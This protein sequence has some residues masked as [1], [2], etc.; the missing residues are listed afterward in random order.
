[1]SCDT[2]TQLASL[3]APEGVAFE[4][5]SYISDIES[6]FGS[7]L[8]WRSGSRNGGK[9]VEELR[10]ELQRTRNRLQESLIHSGLWDLEDARDV[11]GCT[12]NQA[13]DDAYEAASLNM[14][15]LKPDFEQRICLDSLSMLLSWT[16]RP[17]ASD[18]LLRNI[19]GGM[20]ILAR[21]ESNKEG[22]LEVGCVEAMMF[23]IKSGL[24]GAGHWDAVEHA[25]ACISNL[26]LK[27]GPSKER[28]FH[29]GGVGL[30]VRALQGEEWGN[31][32]KAK[33]CSTLSH[34]ACAPAIKK[35]MLREGAVEAMIFVC[36]VSEDEELVTEAVRA[37]RNLASRCEIGCIHILS[38]GGIDVLGGLCMHSRSEKVVRNAAAAISNLC[39]NETCRSECKKKFRWDAAFA[40]RMVARLQAEEVKAARLHPLKALKSSMS[41]R[42]STASSHQ[43]PRGSS[44]LSR[45]DPS[46]FPR[47]VV[48][49][50]DTLETPSRR[51]SSA[52]AR[53]MPIALAASRSPALAAPPARPRSASRASSSSSAGNGAGR[54]RGLWD[55]GTKREL[56]F[57]SARRHS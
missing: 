40:A 50:G 7:N 39:A 36:S 45:E 13:M 41:R 54:A 47:R 11:R 6:D 27:H 53:S 2:F 31:S 55:S 1:M 37:L 22:L 15:A 35:A 52:S 23:L 42:T 51:P 25:S 26:A 46:A 12:Y 28:I 48:F 9:V 18:I 57:R 4:E 43:T 24:E 38:V 33:A 49:A 29:A 56:S 32:M 5:A 8:S 19:A 44:V 17:W 34:L 10:N 30:L 14:L 20:R 21:V 3:E 16:Y